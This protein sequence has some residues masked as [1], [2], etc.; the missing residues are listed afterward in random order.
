MKTAHEQIKELCDLALMYAEDGA[1]L[2]AH[3]KLKEAA[4]VA[5]TVGN[6]NA[7]MTRIIVRGSK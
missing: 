6:R 3:D 7:A 1:Y 2:S 5:K 4:Q